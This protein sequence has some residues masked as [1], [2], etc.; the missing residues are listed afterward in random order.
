MCCQPFSRRVVLSLA[1]LIIG[2]YGCGNPKPPAPT[3]AAVFQGSE[4]LKESTSEVVSD[5]FKLGAKS[6]AIVDVFTGPITVTARA[7]Q[8]VKATV[9]KKAFGKTKD[10]AAENLKALPVTITLEGDTVRI[11]AA[12]PDSGNIA[13]GAETVLEVPPAAD[14]DLKSHN[15]S[16]SVTGVRGAVTAKTSSAAIAVRGAPGVLNLATSFDKIDVSG[17]APDVTARN[18]SGAISVRDATGTLDLITSN[19]P[20]AINGKNTD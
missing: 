15:G 10:E 20:I 16:V 5:T 7:D 3:G 12:R 19:A 2:L 6:R 13:A 4:S 8:L 18:S 14:L 9:T 17:P 11:A 1:V